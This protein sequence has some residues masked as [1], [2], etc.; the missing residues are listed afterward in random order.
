MEK[1]SSGQLSKA[2]QRIL[3]VLQAQS[4]AAGHRHTGRY[5]SNRRSSCAPSTLTKNEEGRMDGCCFTDS[6]SSSSLPSIHPTKDEGLHAL[7]F[8]STCRSVEPT[9]KISFGSSHNTCTA[10]NRLNVQKEEV[11]TKN[12]EHDCEVM[13]QA[14]RSVNEA[15]TLQTKVTAGPLVAC[16]H[17]FDKLH[18]Y[19]ESLGRKCCPAPMT[20][21]GN[22]QQQDSK[23]MYGLQNSSQP[24]S[25]NPVLPASLKRKHELLHDEI[26]PHK[27]CQRLPPSSQHP[28]SVMA[29]PTNCLHKP[30]QKTAGLC[31]LQQRRVN[32]GAPYSYSKPGWLATMLTSDPKVKDAE[33][34]KPDEKRQMF[35][36]VRQAHALLLTMVYRDGSTQLHSGSRLT[37]AVCGLLLLLKND[38]DSTKPQDS[39]GHKDLLLY[40]KLDCTPTWAQQHTQQTHRTFTRDLLLQV[41]SRSQV[42]V[43]YKAKDLL[44]TALQLYRQPISWKQ[45]SGW[46]IQDPQVSGWLLDPAD[47]CSTYQDL[48][49]KHLRASH[50]APA[51]SITPVISDLSSLYW[52]NVELCSKLQ[53]HGLWKLYSDMELNMIPIL[54]AMESHRIHVDKDVVKNMS[55]LLG[56][57]MKQLEQEAHQAAGQMFL[58]TSNIQLRTVLFEKLRLHEV[59]ENKRLPRTFSTQQQSTSEATLLQLQDLHPLPKI[60]LQYRQLH[61]TKSTYVDGILSCMMGKDYISSTW[62]QT[63]AVTGRISSKHP[64]F[65]AIPRQPLRI[66]KRQYIHGNE[67]EVVTVHPRDMFIPQEG[68]TFVAADFCQ[69]ELRLLAHFS[70]DPELLRIFINPCADVFAMLA[71]QWK[72]VSEQEVTSEDREHAKHI[73]YSLVYGAGRERLSGILGVSM[74]QAIQFQNAFLQT[75]RE[76]QAFTQTTIEQSHKQGYVCS[77]MGRR[78]ML[79][80]INSP[81]WGIR[82][83]AERQA[84]NFV[85]Q[86]SAADLCK[87]A[88]IRVFNLVSSS[89]LLSVRLIA[90]L[91]DELLCEVEESQVQEFAAL[92]KCTMESLQHIDHLGVHLKVPLKVAVSSGKF[93]GSMSELHIPPTAPFF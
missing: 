2:A 60:I 68:W 23:P 49:N 71:S 53:S 63:S 48:L 6:R 25:Q 50:S 22:A 84:V 77:I 46:H 81:N 42:A 10:E 72:G 9:L 40:L 32:D 8:P 37:P 55:D 41:L 14:Q 20:L 47:P 92:V 44:C 34:L 54:A 36:L 74:E 65:Q 29:A 61:K 51:R 56:A 90:Q 38:L 76:V 85:L 66:S 39:L 15:E 57:K 43:C 27:I 26:P 93:W 82:M 83:Q 67:E 21:H 19:T 12:A 87:M 1:P 17:G 64:N 16:R 75:Y 30:P 33:V 45:V 11:Q 62:S 78:R 69:V 31:T 7:L 58:I 4:G 70:S 86:G 28:A 18:Y 89:S 35:E 24:S 13:L 80:N 79:H 88:M 59:C 91:H 52:L 5:P 73:V 3:A